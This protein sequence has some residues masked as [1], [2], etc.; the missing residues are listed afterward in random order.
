VLYLL[1]LISV[2]C[3][4]AF[5]DFSGRQV[6]SFEQVSGVQATFELECLFLDARGTNDGWICTFQDAHGVEMEGF[7][8]DAPPAPRA[9]VEI[10]ASLSQEGDFLFID[11]II[12]I[13]ALPDESIN[14]AEGLAARQA[15]YVHR[16][17]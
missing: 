15:A 9:V 6:T 1:S 17:G 4:L 8:K 12:V 3:L 2:C 16:P 10:V 13:R 14:T 5:S 11:R 7:L